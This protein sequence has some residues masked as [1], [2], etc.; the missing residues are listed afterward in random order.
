[1]N[2]IRFALASKKRLSILFLFCACVKLSAQNTAYLAQLRQGTLQKAPDSLIQAKNQV[3]LEALQH[4]LEVNE[5]ITW[6]SIPYV[7]HLQSKDE[8]VDLITWNVLT[9]D[10]IP[11]YFGII[12]YK[13]KNK[14][15]IYILDQKPSVFKEKIN[16]KE[17]LLKQWPGIIYYDMVQ[18]KYKHKPY[19]V[20][21]GFNTADVLVNRKVIDVLSF[22]PSGKPVFGKKVFNI[23]QRWQYRMVFEYKKEVTMSVKYH[24]DEHRI[25]FDHLSPEENS[26]TGFF[27]FYGPDFSYDALELEKDYWNY[28]K[29]VKVNGDI[30]KP[31]N[32][33]PKEK[34]KP[35]YKTK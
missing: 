18:V 27:S 35:I 1:M 10:E 33:D 29:D 5:D 24:Q 31:F 22:T 28:I 32:I 9:K 2:I 17:L 13:H 19:Y 23:D 30:D 25:V 15:N 6:D 34:E 11:K 21:L 4:A 12:R 14:T 8:R 7:S 20:L 16:Q 3:F 26:K